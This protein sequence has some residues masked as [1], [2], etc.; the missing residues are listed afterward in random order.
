MT[1]GFE[2]NYWH[3][4]KPQK[5]LKL[6]RPERGF[7]QHAGETQ[8]DLE[9]LARQQNFLSEIT[10]FLPDSESEAISNYATTQD[11]K[12]DFDFFA[13]ATKYDHFKDSTI[14]HSQTLEV[15]PELRAKL[16]L[17]TISR[18]GLPAS[19]FN[20]IN[21]R[22][23]STDKNF[24]ELI[25]SYAADPSSLTKEDA[26]LLLGA[27]LESRARIYSGMKDLFGDP[28]ETDDQK[29]IDSMKKWLESPTLSKDTK[30]L[31]FVYLTEF[32]NVYSR[33][34]TL[35]DPALSEM[36]DSEEKTQTIDFRNNLMSQLEAY[37]IDLQKT[38]AG[39]GNLP[40]SL[41]E[42]QAELDA[43]NGLKSFWENPALDAT[44]WTTQK[45]NRLL[46]DDLEKP[47]NYVNETISGL[48][49]SILKGTTNQTQEMLDKEGNRITGKAHD[50]LWSV[51]AAGEMR[52]SFD[53]VVT[54]SVRVGSTN[55][56]Q[57]NVYMKEMQVYEEKVLQ[58]KEREFEE[59][60][61][62]KKKQMERLA[63]AK[64]LENKTITSIVQRN[65]EIIQYTQKKQK[66]FQVEQ[67][68]AAARSH[69]ALK[70]LEKQ[71]SVQNQVA[72]NNQ[73]ARSSSKN[74]KKAREA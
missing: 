2:E 15:L 7:F 34:S 49:P 38:I 21:N 45:G 67:K 40:L 53:Q 32:Q 3:I 41:E 56:N 14:K 46:S 17:E 19:V 25:E 74:Q 6:E 63:E 37:K 57:Y 68:K 70:A 44:G 48:A 43:L 1:L 29:R 65:K 10:K 5:P 28:N 61:L 20:R 58:E 54:D 31:F 8:A 60:K 66:E 73:K 27:M 23:D 71:F 9:F 50:K 42:A 35:I 47:L 51:Y 16:G 24:N 52:K 18:A 12:D 39:T 26:F 69:Q 62:E 72:Q 59:K 22:F 36:P 64:K 55:R 11:I 4:P 33:I 30:R 13:S